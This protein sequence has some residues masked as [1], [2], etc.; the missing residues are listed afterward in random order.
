MS[1]DQTSV[2]SID[3]REVRSMSKKAEVNERL[4][5]KN[6]PEGATRPSPLHEPG[7]RR[8]GIF[9]PEAFRDRCAIEAISR[10]LLTTEHQQSHVTII[11]PL[12]VLI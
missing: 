4:F 8:Y 5:Q 3:A 6:L 2:N 10:V 7:C 12:N 11:L 1:I 9:L